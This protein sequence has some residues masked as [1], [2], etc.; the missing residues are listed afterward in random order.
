MSDEYHEKSVRMV[1][2][3]LKFERA[4]AN[5]MGERCRGWPRNF[6]WRQEGACPISDGVIRILLEA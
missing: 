1:G 5:A 3:K 6:I 2:A 4:P